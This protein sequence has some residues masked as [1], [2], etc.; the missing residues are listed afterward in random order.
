MAS[1]KDRAAAMKAAL[2]EELPFAAAAPRVAAPNADLTSD[3]LG[4]RVE[5]HADEF[6][7]VRPAD[8][9]AVRL[10]DALGLP[11]LRSSDQAAAEPVAEP[12][13]EQETDDTATEPVAE[14]E[15]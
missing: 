14:Q 6:G 2:A 3:V 8:P 1:K 7:I 11:I 10:A 4:R 15:T 12:V 5:L 13:A 9:D